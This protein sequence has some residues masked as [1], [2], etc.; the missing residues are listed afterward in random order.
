M[1]RNYDDVCRHR[2]KLEHDIQ[3]TTHEKNILDRQ[4]TETQ[5]NVDALQQREKERTPLV[6][7]L[8]EKVEALKK[9]NE[10]AQT[11]S[12]QHNR[13]EIKKLK[14]QLLSI[15]EEN[16]SLAAAQEKTN[17]LKQEFG[18]RLIEAQK[19]LSQ[20]DM[21]LQ[22]YNKD[23]DKLR[24]EYEGQ[25]S[26]KRKFEDLEEK[27][28]PFQEQLDAYELEKRALLNRN[29]ESQSEID[30]LGQQYARLLGHQNQKQKIR[31]VQ[32]LMDENASLKQEVVT[33]REEVGKERFSRKRLDEKLSK[34]TGTRRFDPSRAFKHN[35]YENKENTPLKQHP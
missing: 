22:N 14:D 30:K 10:T 1:K 18:R 23:L 9:E 7:T 2:V 24:A 31:H 3:V 11:E 6:E 16:R 20:K 12:T 32:K 25:D 4:L 26:W 17:K 29:T 21:E 35:A 5:K 34:A 19:N 27:I 15:Q 28:A 8:R 33:L 13:D